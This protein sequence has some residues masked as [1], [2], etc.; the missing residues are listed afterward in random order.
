MSPT[1]EGMT[2]EGDIVIVL[3]G[4]AGSVIWLSGTEMSVLLRNG[5]I[6]TGPKRGV[7]HPQDAADLASCPVDVERTPTKRKARNPYEVT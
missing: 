2:A 6:W 3:T 1:P 5:D 7:R 4:Q